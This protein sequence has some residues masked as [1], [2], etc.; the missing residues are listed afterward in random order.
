MA[1]LGRRTGS[2]VALGTIDPNQGPHGIV[3]IASDLATLPPDLAF[4]NQHRTYVH[5][6]GNVL[7]ARLNPEG[8]NGR[9]P[10][11]VYG[12][13]TN[14]VDKDTGQR[15]EDCVYGEGDFAPR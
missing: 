7:D 12:D 6:P 13:Q 1:Q 2:D 11:Y 5:E 15:L 10:G 4:L 3:F 9:D 8:K 14:D